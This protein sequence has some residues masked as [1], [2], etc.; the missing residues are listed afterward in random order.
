MQIYALR[1][2]SPAMK[3]SAPSP[4]TRHPALSL[5]LLLG[6]LLGAFC[7]ATFAIVVYGKITLGTLNFQAILANPEGN[8]NGWTF[9]MGVQALSLLIGFGGAALAFA[10]VSGYRWT[11]YFAPRRSVPGWA[12]L[13]AAVL[14]I[15]LLPLMSVLVEWN[16]KA[17]FPAF[18]HDFEVWARASE[19]KNSG[20]I[21]FLT[22]FTTPA[23]FLAGLF[24]V[25]VTPAIAEELFFRGVVQRN[26]VQWFSPHAGIWL[27]AAVF[28][29]IHMQFFGFFPRFLLGLVL[30]YLYQW[31]GN[32]LV[33]MTAHFTQNAFQLVLLYLQQRHVITLDL[34][35]DKSTASWPLALL[36]AALSLGLLYY[37]HQRLRPA[38]P[39]EM[40]TLSSGGVA[41]ATAETPVPEGHI[42]SAQGVLPA[43]E[44]APLE[45]RLL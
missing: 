45:N 36:S 20:V 23:R 19:D 17:H 31:S 22:K 4:T 13:A 42:L 29:A 12:L 10:S 44:Q 18:L 6:L 5:L 16:A 27:A 15:V 40:H 43:S 2:Q 14:I 7:V 8:R 38:I 24:V 32:I 28:S 3:G 37:L 9:M 39:T 34:D 26:L 30:G 1:N 33:S 35:S 25:A 11:D 41:I 21:K